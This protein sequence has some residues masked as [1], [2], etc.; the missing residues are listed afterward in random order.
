[1]PNFNYRTLSKTKLSE[2]H[3]SNPVVIVIKSNHEMIRG[4]TSRNKLKG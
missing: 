2:R 4:K 1:M 3:P